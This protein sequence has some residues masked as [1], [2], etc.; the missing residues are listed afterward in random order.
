MTLSR[1]LSHSIRVN[2]IHLRYSSQP[3][4]TS[5]TCFNFISVSYRLLQHVL[6]WGILLA[7]QLQVYGTIQDSAMYAVPVHLLFFTALCNLQSFVTSCVSEHWHFPAYQATWFVNVQETPEDSM[8]AA[9]KNMVDALLQAGLTLL[10][11]D[12]SLDQAYFAQLLMLFRVSVRCL[13]FMHG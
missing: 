4:G 11:D 10:R 5:N 6:A 12:R 9:V 2:T 13:F 3:S 8:P 1:L 7:V